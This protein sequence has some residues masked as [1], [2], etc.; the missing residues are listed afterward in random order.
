MQCNQCRTYVQKE[1]V[2]GSSLMVAH[3]LTASRWEEEEGEVK[4]SMVVGVYYSCFLL[5]APAEWAGAEACLE[6]EARRP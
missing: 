2:F 4:K 6:A 5:T 3:E 1:S